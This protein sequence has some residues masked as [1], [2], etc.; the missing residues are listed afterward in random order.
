MNLRRGFTLIELLVVMA[1][2]ALLLSIA[3]PRYFNHLDRS[4][5]NAL[6]ESLFVMR[7][8]IDKY[9]AD[10]GEFPDSLEDLVDSNYLRAIPEDPITERRDTWITLPPRS[11]EPD[12]IGD[13]V[14]GAGAPY[15]EW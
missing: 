4:R 8:A 6:K 2:V 11:G 7:D 12:G 9:A 10:K 14:S 15:S 13:V 1:V 3:A 5:E